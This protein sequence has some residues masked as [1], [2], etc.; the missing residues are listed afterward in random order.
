MRLKGAAGT[1]TNP[2]ADMSRRESMEEDSACRWF[3]SMFGVVLLALIPA[4]AAATQVKLVNYVAYTYAGSTADLTTDGVQNLDPEDASGP[5][6]L[7]LWAFASAYDGA[8]TGSRLAVSPLAA[9]AAGQRTAKIDSGPVPYV[10]PA[11]GVWYYAMLLTEYDATVAT[12]DSY[13]MRHWINFPD[14][15]YVGVAP[16]PRRMPAI[17]FY[18]PGLDHYFVAASM[19]D[20]TDLDTGVHPGWIRTGYEFVVWDAATATAGPVCRYYIPPDYGDS[21]FFSASA[22]ECSVVTTQFPLLVKESDAAFYIAL[23]DAGT[24][25]CTIDEQP[26]YR[27]WNGRPDSNHRY[28]T[29]VDVK[30]SMI[31]QGYVA[32]GYGPDAVAMCAPKN[33]LYPAA[34]P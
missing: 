12:N 34:A 27:L 1:E 11:D 5:L 2:G 32:E 17:E 28:T 14:A 9:L 4:V 20:I 24:G 33:L 13:A 25:A 6:R 15:V 31:G 10:Q 16:P 26:V 30:A 18:H 22:Y 8:M 7:E 23:P 29:S 21:H 19:Q 3:L